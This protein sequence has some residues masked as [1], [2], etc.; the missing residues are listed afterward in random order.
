MND[1][2]YIDRLKNGNKEWAEITRFIIDSPKQT[3]TK[4]EVNRIT[5]HI[6]GVYAGTRDVG[7]WKNLIS[8]V[9][10]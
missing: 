6:E 8:W 10:E 1:S 3:Y 7:S 9:F 5:G 2:V 4:D